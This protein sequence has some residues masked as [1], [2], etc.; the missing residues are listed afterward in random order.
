MDEF[1]NYSLSEIYEI[2][3]E[4]GLDIPVGG[5]ELTKGGWKNGR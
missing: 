3:L 1:L 4:F 5:D 2:D